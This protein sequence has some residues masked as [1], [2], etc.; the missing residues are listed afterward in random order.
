[1]ADEIALSGYPG[2]VVHDHGLEFQQELSW[3]QME[4]L[5]DDLQGMWVWS[6]EKLPLY[7]G[8]WMCQAELQWGEKYV[9]LVKVTGLATETLR[10]Y[11]WMYE[12]TTQ[13]ARQIVSRATNL[14]NTCL[15]HVAA[16]PPPEQEKWLLKAEQEQMTSRELKAAI[17]ANGNVAPIPPLATQDD[18]SGSDAT[19]GWDPGAEDRAAVVHCLSDEDYRGACDACGEMELAIADGDLAECRRLLE[20]VEDCLGMK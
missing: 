20:V 17:R 14:G 13:E 16:L 11:K 1:M 15:R 5:G 7:L 3:T 19:Q 2:L 12:R 10:G 4:R 18:L 6:R 9:Q 8:A